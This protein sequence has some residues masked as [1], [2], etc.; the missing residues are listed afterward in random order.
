MYTESAIRD[1]IKE[2]LKQFHKEQVLMLNPTSLF[3]LPIPENT[4]LMEFFLEYT[5]EFRGI[6]KDAIFHILTA[7]HKNNYIR[8]DFITLKVK[9]TTPEKFTIK[10]S[11]ISSD[12]INSP[13]SFNALVIEASERKSY[14]KEAYMYCPVRKCDNRGYY[15]G[16]ING[17][18]SQM[19]N[20]HG[21]N[22][23]NL[24]LDK[25]KCRYS[26]FQELIFQEP[27]DESRNNSPLE[28]EGIIKDDQVGDVFAGQKKH[29]IGIFQ[30]IADTKS[31]STNRYKHVI[32]AISINEFD[33]KEDLP[34]EEELEFF[35]KES[36]KPDYFLNAS[37]S[38]APHIIGMDDVKE[39]I[40]L[41]LVG[42][43]SYKD[44]RDYSNTFLIGDPGVAKTQLLLAAMKLE[45]KSLYTVGSGGSKA[46]LTIATIKR[47]NGTFMAQAGAL[48]QCDEGLVC[49]DEFD[50]MNPEDR[51]AMHEAMENGQCTNTKVVK[52]TLQ[53]R[54]KILAAANPLK[55]KF[56]PTESIRDQYDIPPALLTRF[57]NIWNIIDK[58]TD[59]GDDLIGHQ[60]FAQYDENNNLTEGYFD[61]DQLRKLIAYTKKLK[62]KL[63]K[64]AETRLLQFYKQIRAKSKDT[65]QV[66][67][68]PRHLHGLIRLSFAHAKFHFKKVADIKDAEA[69]CNIL[70][71]SLDSLNVDVTSVKTD[72]FWDSKK[73]NKNEAIWNIFKKIKD[74]DGSVDLNEFMLELATTPYFTD[75]TA[76]H[77]IE[78]KMIDGTN[79]QLRKLAGG[80]YVKI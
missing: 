46:G 70:R 23:I 19:C 20:E 47:P 65:N 78:S 1:K 32:E 52:I 5:G 74:D 45:P 50:K 37:K 10:L 75:Y 27:L 25:T 28:F 41:Q 51:N 44:V 17:I 55:G 21:K 11:D 3:T 71:K 24:I 6:V 77:F 7:H 73:I 66:H 22:E 35:K 62:P 79:Q 40:L 60:I 34:T 33:V 2:Y 76:Q 56:D 12:L 43:V 64:E 9:I 57:D 53:A 61:Y 63:N 16:T 68:V 80:R 30:A 54:T 42:G 14:I 49:C 72:T 58:I 18:R 8:E 48:P 4:Q 13:V 39:N 67:I 29:V 38:I 31:K 69:A 36:S 59:T 26:F 15:T